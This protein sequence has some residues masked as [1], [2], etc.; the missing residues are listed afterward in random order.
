MGKF[1]Q[2]LI[3]AIIIETKTVISLVKILLKRTLKN[4]Y[5]DSHC[6]LIIIILEMMAQAI[7]CKQSFS[8]NKNRSKYAFGLMDIPEFEIMIHSE[9]FN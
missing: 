7:C 2:I 9:K 8:I 6:I 5:P 3:V 4:P 1:E